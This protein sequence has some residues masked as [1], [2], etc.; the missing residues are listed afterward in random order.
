MTPRLS[1]VLPAFRAVDVVGGS[2]ARL[3]ADLAGLGDDLEIVVVDDGSGDGT[4]EAAWTA[5]A[6]QVIT[7]PVNRGKGAAVRAG[8]LA[9]R[10]DT[11]AFTDVDLSYAP[12]QLLRLLAVV[13][14]GTDVVTG[15]RLHADTTTLVQASRLRG[16][17]GRLFGVVAARLV[18]GGQVRD[19]QCGLKAFSASAA[20][21]IFP[22]VRTDG[23]AFDVE[24]LALA[25]RLGLRVEEVPVEVSNSDDSTV[26]VA[27]QAVRMLVDLLR[28]RAN[29]PAQA[30][31]PAIPGGR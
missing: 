13:E 27:R 6:D 24:V 7:L 15:S 29:L 2:V 20:A 19:T 30:R 16:V 10:G 5:G 17:A 14:G 4:A 8:V 22:A 25:L 11:V 21:R 28:I 12:A 9:A 1:V 23:F 26:R 3:R 18:L 31:E